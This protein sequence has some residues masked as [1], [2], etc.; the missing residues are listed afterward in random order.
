MQ[1]EEAVT[2]D[3]I[4]HDEVLDDPFAVFKKQALH[5]QKK[6]EDQNKAAKANAIIHSKS[7]GHLTSTDA[8]RATMKLTQSSS[9]SSVP[10]P[11]KEPAIMAT[12][13]D[14][15]EGANTKEQKEKVVGLKPNALK[16]KRQ[17]MNTSGDW[18]SSDADFSES[19]Y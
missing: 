9:S 18:M 16:H 7:Q 3:G 10:P 6:I 5:K 1:V 8:K 15:Q 13:S 4:F 14:A 17:S 12:G 19:E 2:T 11:I